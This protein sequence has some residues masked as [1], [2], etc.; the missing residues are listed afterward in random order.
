MSYEKGHHPGAVW[1]KSDL[2]CH[3]PRDRNWKGPPTLPGGS[4]SGED[5]RRAWATAFINECGHR[6]IE[7]I[8]ITDHHDMAFVP[9]VLEAAEI[10]FDSPL[11]FPGVEITCS[12]KAQCLVLFDPATGKSE[13]HHFLGKLVGVEQSNSDAVKIAPIKN[14]GMTVHELFDSVTSDPRLRD[15]CVILPHFSDGAAHKHLNEDGHHER[16]ATLKCDGVY[17]EKPFADL[18]KVTVDK[19]YGRIFEWGSRRRAFVATGDNHS[20]TW[21]RLGAHECWIKLGE[22]SIE[23]MR[24]ALLADE[25]RISYGTP[26]APSERIVKLSVL[27]TLTGPEALII[28]L[29]DGFNALIGGRGAGKSALLEYL[30]FG[31]GRTNRDLPGRDDD[32]FE[33]DYDRDFQLIE[34]TLGG[35]GYVEVRI[36]R[37]G[38]TETW[39]RDLQNRDIIK[40]TDDDG[41]STELTIQDAQRRFRARAFYQKGLSTTM[42]DSANAAEQITGIAAA[43]QIDQRREIDASI[44]K[45]KRAIGTA[46]RRQSAFWQIRLEHKRA[47]ALVSDLKRRISAVSTKLEKEGLSKETLAVIAQASLYDRAKSYQGQVNRARTADA[48]RLNQIKKTLLNVALS[49]FQGVEAFPEIKALDSALT[50]TRAAITAHL[51]AA[52]AEVQK[53]D[54]VY[55]TSLQQFGERGAQFKTKLQAAITAQTTH[56]QLIDEH[57]RLIAELQKAEQSALEVAEQEEEARGAPA[58]FNEACTELDQLIKERGKVLEEAALRVEGQS[59]QMLKAR[60]KRDPQPEEYVQA[61]TGLMAGARVHDMEEKTADWV[62]ET[63]RPDAERSWQSVRRALIDLY[64]SKINAGLPPEPSD[65]DA[66]MLRSIIFTQSTLT[67]Q[68]TLKVYQN[69]SDETLAK[70]FAAAPRDYIVMTYIDQGRDVPFEQASPGQQASALLELLLQQSAGTL[71]V[72]QPEDD[73]DNRVIMKIVGLIRTSKSG[74]QLLFATHNPNI[75]VNGDA[76]KVVVLQSG[77]PKPGQTPVA[78]IQIDVDGAIET[79]AVRDAIT[80]V[81]EGGREAF[82]LRTRKYNFQTTP[83]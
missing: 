61:I 75:V 21:E 16:F 13:W 59:S 12:D 79:P 64:E 14:A 46:I 55:L 66:E 71:I 49:Q 8:S 34:D 24:Q 63:V 26:A 1:R 10:A 50:E 39:R 37:E 81:M 56:K 25:A 2:Q 53:L 11:V 82:D 48:E 42:N 68:Q 60:L 38:V 22:N 47:Q 78:R 54:L 33:I 74:R 7:I 15:V 28:S 18:D 23:A 77:E 20:L 52:I 51:D 72:D 31:L 40:I 3:S 6:G 44:D 17:I 76:D 9:Y 70:I 80:H 57:S 45:A 30:R 35:D 43:E 19:A 65:E 41:E 83:S 5:S 29:N 32:P 58:F 27:S 36:E 67:S 4:Q 73:L 69:L 62:R